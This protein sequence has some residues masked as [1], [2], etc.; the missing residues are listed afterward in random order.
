MTT[1]EEHGQH[2]D[3]VWIQSRSE[4][5]KEKEE[6]RV[7]LARHGTQKKENESQTQDVAGPHLA[8]FE[9][10]QL[11]SHVEVE[12][13]RL[14]HLAFILAGVKV[15]D[16]VDPSAAAVNDPVVSVKGLG[17]AQDVVDARL[18][19]QRLGVSAERDKLGATASV[20]AKPLSATLWF[21]RYAVYSGALT[22][23]SRGPSPTF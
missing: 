13:E 9:R 15:N 19:C 7:S 5:R 1:K 3:D 14:A 4:R 2:D 21:L 10:V 16:I 11:W 8:P 20:V 18:W 12:V 17:V 6:S 22:F 23:P